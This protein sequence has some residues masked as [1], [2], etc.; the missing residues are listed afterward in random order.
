MNEAF[1]EEMAEILEE[2]IGNITPDYSLS[3]ENFDSLAIVATLALIDDIFEVTVSGKELRK[4]KD[5]GSI[6]RLVEKAMGK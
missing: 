1:L 4:V 3:K 2:D 6:L 5:I